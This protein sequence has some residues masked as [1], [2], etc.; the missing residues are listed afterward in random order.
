L[1]KAGRIGKKAR[2]ESEKNNKARGKEASQHSKISESE[3]AL[4]C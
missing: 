3:K 1:G 4:R 2:A